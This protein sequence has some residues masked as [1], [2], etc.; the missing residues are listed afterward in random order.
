[1]TRTTVGWSEIVG[2]RPVRV[3]AEERLDCGGRVYLRWREHGYWRAVAT[4]VLVRTREGRLIQSRI[5]EA[6]ALAKRR[7]EELA[8]G[9]A[10]TDRR[11]PLTILDGLQ[12]AIDPHRGK[13][14]VDS[15]HRREVIR[16]LERVAAILPNGMT[17]NALRPAD[18]REVYRKRA[19]ALHA[20]GHVGRRGA[21][22]TV[23]RLL[24]VAEWLRGEGLVD[25]VACRPPKDWKKTLGEEVTQA[26]PHRPRYT[27][28]ELRRILRE[29]RQV[30]PRFALMTHLGIGLRL[31]QV[32][33]VRRRHVDLEAR[34]LRVPG[35]GHKGGAIVALLDEDLA[36]ITDAMAGY[37]APL[38]A[39]Y[40]AG[41]IGD[42]PLFPSG[43]L[44]GG[45]R[46]PRT[47]VCR[48]DQ[49]T[50]APVGG[51]AI[52]KW[53]AAAEQGAGVAHL[54]GRGT[55]GAKRRSVDKAKDLQISRDELASFGG[56]ADTQMADRVYADQASRTA[57]E[58]AARARALIR[59]LDEPVT[60]KT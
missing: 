3:I 27:L 4:D 42:Y 58:G 24:A 18:L 55:Y 17:F 54:P 31:G 29:A 20:A 38:E 37:L 13:Y 19:A 51:S 5:K 7:S 44:R 50:A 39:L 28:D 41:A 47:A 14:P 52:R 9:L 53:W 60:P 22:I 36:A 35:R 57:A 1:M 23:S 32:A 30:D 16:E 21:E 46:D 26:G 15:M 10:P 2:A 8:L 43:Q 48:P 33:R 25:A 59:G 34:S 56:W 40:T 49:A 12:L 6:L 11:T 45:R